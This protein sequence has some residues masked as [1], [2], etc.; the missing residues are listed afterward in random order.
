MRHSGSSLRPL[1][2]THGTC[3]YLFSLVSPS[4]CKP[5]SHGHGMAPSR[6][7]VSVGFPGISLDP[8]AGELGKEAGLSPWPQFFPLPSP[9]CE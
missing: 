3:H 4:D 7:L 6:G 1:S 8:R 5:P 2:T 9:Q